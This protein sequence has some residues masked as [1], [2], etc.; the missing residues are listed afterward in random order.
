[1][2]TNP[3]LLK[4]P[5]R[6]RR[7]NFG[8]KVL[9]KIEKNQ[10]KIQSPPT[11]KS[12]TISILKKKKKSPTTTTTI[13]ALFVILPNST[14]SVFNKKQQKNQQTYKKQHLLLDTQLVFLDIIQQFRIYN[15]LFHK[16]SPLF[17]TILL[18]K[19][20]VL[21]SRLPLWLQSCLPLLPCPLL[22]PWPRSRLRPHSWRPLCPSSFL[23]S[24][25]RPHSWRPLCPSSFLDSCLRQR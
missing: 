13:L 5:P 2:G 19:N 25:L 12:F 20:N 3:E 1:M 15:L 10:K 7:V 21:T 6:R 23:D 8:K 11:Q 16:C 4:S 9:F 14:L 18:K 17:S 24:C 22:R